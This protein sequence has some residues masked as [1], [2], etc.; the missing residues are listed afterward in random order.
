MKRD[1]D[2]DFENYMKLNVMANRN[3]RRVTKIARIKLR[4]RF[5][6][7]LIPLV[8]CGRIQRHLKRLNERNEETGR[9]GRPLNKS[10]AD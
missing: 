3:E 1:T 9:S 8:I 7:T 5:A 2:L 6:S 10:A 4:T